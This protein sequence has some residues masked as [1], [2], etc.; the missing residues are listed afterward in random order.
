LLSDAEISKFLGNGKP[1][2]KSEVKELMQKN[3]EHYQKYGFCLFDV[4]LRSTGEFIGDAG[5]IYEALNSENKNIEVG[6]RL[7]KKHWNKGY[8]TEL[9]RAFIK[10]GFDNFHFSRIVA[11]CM[12]ENAASSNVMKKCGMKYK[13]KYLYNGKHECDIYQI[14]NIIIQTEI[15]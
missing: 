4:F 5:L 1:K 8:A 14:D 2:T 11:C 10:W 6:Y 15:L 9:A 7:L 13:G 12:P 3:I